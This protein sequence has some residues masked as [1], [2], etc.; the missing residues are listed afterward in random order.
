[1]NMS[2]G[3]EKRQV[4]DRDRVRSRKLDV[5]LDF[6]VLLRSLIY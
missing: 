4:F 2:V 3:S 1:M 6:G 5:R